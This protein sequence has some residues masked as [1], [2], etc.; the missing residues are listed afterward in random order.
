MKKI[1]MDSFARI[2][3]VTKSF[4]LHSHVEKKKTE[5]KSEKRVTETKK[6]K[7]VE[8]NNNNIFFLSV[9]L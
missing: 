7:K 8:K 1:S 9:F 2:F 5:K 4:Y 3:F 6:R